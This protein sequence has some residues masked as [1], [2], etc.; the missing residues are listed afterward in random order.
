MVIFLYNLYI[1]DRIQ[2]HIFVYGKCPKILYSEVVDKMSYANSADPD[3]TAPKGA[4]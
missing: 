4:V 1:F 2:H 3:Q